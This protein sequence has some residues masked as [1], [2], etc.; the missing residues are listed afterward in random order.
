MRS[1]ITF[2]WKSFSTIFQSQIQHSNG[3][4]LIYQIELKQSTSI[5]PSLQHRQRKLWNPTRHSLP[6][7]KKLTAFLPTTDLTSTVLRTTR[8]CTWQQ[9]HCSTIA[10]RLQHCIAEVAVWC[11]ARRLQLNPTKTEIMWFGSATALRNLPSSVRPLNVGA[12]VVQP[13]SA[14]RDPN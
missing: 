5:N 13:T 7:G 3:L 1:I 2:S 6:T 9:Y 12:V 14:V 11:G 10:S 4:A 8:K